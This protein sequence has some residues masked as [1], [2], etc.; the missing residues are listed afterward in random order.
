M[1][2]VEE[3]TNFKQTLRE[4]GPKTFTS[5]L[6]AIIIWLFSVLVFIPIASSIGKNVELVIVLITLSA[7]SAIILVSLRGVKNLLD[8]FSVIPARKYFV[9]ERAFSRIRDFSFKTISICTVDF[10]CLFALFS[11]LG[12]STSCNQRYS[13]DLCDYITISNI[14]KYCKYLKEG[15]HRLALFHMNPSEFNILLQKS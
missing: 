14:A 8:V 12:A 10:I 9:Q 3:I 4:Q 1:V 7:F 11:L 15:N 5:L 2:T 6:S 13:P